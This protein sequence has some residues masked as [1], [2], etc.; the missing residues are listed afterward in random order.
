MY[1]LIECLSCRDA[2]LI[3]CG[4]P[5]FTDGG[6]VGAHDSIKYYAATQLNLQTQCLKLQTIE[7][8]ARPGGQDIATNIAMKLNA[9]M[10][11][12]NWV[13]READGELRDLFKSGG[14]MVMG[15]DVNH[16]P[17]KRG[18]PGKGVTE[19]SVVAVVASIDDKVFQVISAYYA[20]FWVCSSVL[21][22]II[23]AWSSVCFNLPLFAFWL[24][25]LCF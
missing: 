17:P 14:L 19:P 23:F 4:I 16:P 7:R 18:I 1:S 10:G 6:W 2:D 25:V 24:W 15:A 21:A 11:G 5:N 12:V 3:L 9:K 22:S 20:D 8:I 13:L